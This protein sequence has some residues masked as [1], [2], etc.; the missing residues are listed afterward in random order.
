MTTISRHGDTRQ[1][2][3]EINVLT[4]SAKFSIFIRKAF[5]IQHTYLSYK[6][7][8]VVSQKDDE[9]VLLIAPSQ[10]RDIQQLLIEKTDNQGTVEL[11]TLNHQGDGEVLK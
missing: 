2:S 11:I 6:F 4:G 7:R 5:E 10:L 1:N 9:L 3:K 8:T